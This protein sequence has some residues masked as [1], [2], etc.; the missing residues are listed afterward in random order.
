MMNLARAPAAGRNWE[1]WGPDPYLSG[2]GAAETIK[3]IQSQ[4]VQA[5]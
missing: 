5:T 4:G 3:G 1:G 2:E